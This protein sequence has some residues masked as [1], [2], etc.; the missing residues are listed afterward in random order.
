MTEIVAFDFDRQVLTYRDGRVIARTPYHTTWDGQYTPEPVLPT[1]Q[2]L[3]PDAPVY[4]LSDDVF[5]AAVDR[6]AK[7]DYR[8]VLEL[9]RG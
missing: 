4:R 1:I 3:A 8:F 7:W 2:A 9:A 6:V 5:T